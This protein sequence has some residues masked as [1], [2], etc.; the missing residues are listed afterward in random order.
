MKRFQLNRKDKHGYIITGYEQIQEN[1]T[2]EDAIF[3][4]LHWLDDPGVTEDDIDV[5]EIDWEE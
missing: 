3:D 1:E 2:K 4:Y 5:Q